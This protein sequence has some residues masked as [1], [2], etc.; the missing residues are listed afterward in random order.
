MSLQIPRDQEVRHRLSQWAGQQEAVRALLL[1]SSR[2]NPQASPDLLSD[3]DVVLIVQ[4]IY[5]FFEGRSWLQDFG[6]VLVTYWD[7][8]PLAADGL[9]QV[10]NVVQY[11]DGLHIDFTLWPLAQWRR[12]ASAPTLP[13]DLDDGYT[14]L[15]DKDGLTEGLPAPTYTIYVPTPP[16]EETYQRTIEEFFSDVPYVA[17]CLWRDELLPAKWCLD[18][19]MKY[20]YLYPLLEW[21]L[22][23]DHHWSAP[24]GYQGKGLKKRLPPAIWSQLERTYA[25]AGIAENWEA[26]FQTMA[27]FGGVAAEIGE[28]LGYEYPAALQ[29]KVTAYARWI[30]QLKQ[31]AGS[32]FGDESTLAASP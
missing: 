27:L 1:T 26:L 28:Q 6:E 18:Y 8:L 24:A 16:S 20:N 31:E 15:V 32:P 21:R 13:A 5:P 17:K 22:A 19:D 29:Q 25:G 14:V 30:E 9:E 2:A 7:P 4:D 23:C 3:Y 10:G 12:M 11:A